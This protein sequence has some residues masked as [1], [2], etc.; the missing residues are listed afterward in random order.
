M[1]EN[2][3]RALAS[4]AAVENLKWLSFKDSISLKDGMRPAKEEDGL[5]ANRP[6]KREPHIVYTYMLG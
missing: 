5:H 4:S 3:S 2:A 1:N 6:Y